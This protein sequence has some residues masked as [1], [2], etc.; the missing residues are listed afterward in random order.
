MLHLVPK[1]AYSTAVRT[2]C[3]DCE[4]NL[5]VLRVISGRAGAEYWATQCTEC[6]GVHLD[7][8]K[9]TS[10]SRPCQA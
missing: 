2:R 10:T 3:P 7:I 1:I 6:K 8:L 4:G 5:A 9:S